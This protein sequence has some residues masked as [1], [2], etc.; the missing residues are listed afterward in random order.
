MVE[1]FTF[2]SGAGGDPKQ[3]LKWVYVSLYHLASGIKNFLQQ[4]INVCLGLWFCTQVDKNM[5]S[6]ALT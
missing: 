4:L 6:A 5:N 1:Q 3:N 2:P